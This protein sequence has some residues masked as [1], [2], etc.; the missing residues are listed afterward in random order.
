MGFQAVLFTVVHAPVQEYPAIGG[1][2]RRVR[3]ASPPLWVG[4]HS[5]RLRL[6]R[7]PRLPLTMTMNTVNCELR[8]RGSGTSFGC[9]KAL[10]SP[11]LWSSK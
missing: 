4:V 11:R 2:N 5:L 9:F 8:L 3:A 7:R 6:R 10:M 1:I